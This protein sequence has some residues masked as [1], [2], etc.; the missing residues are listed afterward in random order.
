[1]RTA[2]LCLIAFG[3]LLFAVGRLRERRAYARIT[4]ARLM[5]APMPGELMQVVGT[6]IVF[7]ALMACWMWPILT[8][9]L[10]F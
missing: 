3:V 7:L 2:L 6:T 1:M 5:F 9:W 4:D 8:F 10:A